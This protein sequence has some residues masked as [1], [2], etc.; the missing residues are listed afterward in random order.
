MTILFAGS[1]LA[2]NVFASHGADAAGKAGL[3]RPCVRREQLPEVVAKL[4]P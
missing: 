4:P 2:K 1:D 3:V